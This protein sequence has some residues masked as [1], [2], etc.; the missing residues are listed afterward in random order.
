MLKKYMLEGP[1]TEEIV[2]NDGDQYFD[3]LVTAVKEANV[4]IHFESYIFCQDHLGHRLLDELALAT[5]RGVKVQLLLDGVGCNQWSFSDAEKQRNRGIQVLFFH[6][7][8]WQNQESSLSRFLNFRNLAQS[9]Y[10]TNHRN[11]RKICTIDD[12]VLF[13]GSFNVMDEELKNRVTG[14]AWRDTGLKL[15]GQGIQKYINS[16]QEAWNYS[17]LYQVQKA[18]HP[19]FYFFFGKIGLKFAKKD[20]ALFYHELFS[21]I[22]QA[23]T[24]IWIATPYF[25]PDWKL[26]RT[27]KQ[28]SQN[29][30]DV[31]LLLPNRS[32]FFG[33]KFATES[34]YDSLLK[35]GI[36][37]FEYQPSMLHAKIF[38]VDEWICIG[39]SNLD[40]RSLFQDLEANAVVSQHENI[41]LIYDQFRNDL[42]HSKTIELSHWKQRPTLQ[43]G[44][45]LFFLFFKRML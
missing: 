42:E 18:Q 32:D 36:K 5:Q 12:E 9:I 24:K 34:F 20:H 37:I 23:K 19:N 8:P 40:H 15:R 22:R 44:F 35:S 38:C 13:I 28:S 16:C 17:E 45:E 2:F 7:L 31:R 26:L 14:L 6:P 4:S 29:G 27:L 30:I 11:H 3:A 43:K 21:R 33:V 39:S 10:K 1:W 25:V 41:R